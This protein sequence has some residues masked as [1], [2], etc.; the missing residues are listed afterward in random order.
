LYTTLA[1]AAGNVGLVNSTPSH[2]DG[3]ARKS[4]GV[5]WFTG[6]TAY[7]STPVRHIPRIAPRR[8]SAERS[9]HRGPPLERARAIATRTAVTTEQFATATRRQH[10]VASRASL[11]VAL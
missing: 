6:R 11:R 10:D 3:T 9:R 2:V 7:E 1:F 8:I 4:S 5:R